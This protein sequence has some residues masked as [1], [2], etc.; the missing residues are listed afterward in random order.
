[1]NVPRQVKRWVSPLH[2]LPIR[3]PIFSVVSY[4]VQITTFNDWGKKNQG[5]CKSIDHSNPVE[6]PSFRPWKLLSLPEFVSIYGSDVVHVLKFGFAYA[7]DILE[8]IEF[9]SDM[10]Y[11]QGASKYYLPPPIPS[12]AQVAQLLVKSMIFGWSTYDL[13][14]ICQL[15]LTTIHICGL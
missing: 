13:K 9:D 7:I 15:W 2:F 3:V 14:M 6:V 5:D 4:S 11:V 12:R 1:M 10:L 8:N